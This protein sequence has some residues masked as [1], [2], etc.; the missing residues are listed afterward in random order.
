MNIRLIEAGDAENFL[1]LSKK[2]DESGFMLFDP[3]ERQTSVEQQRKSIEGML[4]QPN[5]IFFVAEIEN[6]LAGYIGVLGSGL[7][8]NQHSATIV[9]GVQETYQGKGV[10]TKLFNKAFEWAKEAGILRL[11]LTVLKHNHKAFNLYKKMGFVLE[12]ERVHSLKIEGEFVNE[13]YLYKLL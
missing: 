3:G 1:E 6:E 5:T 8:R 4:S 11:G 13:Y 7:N 9:L 12:G 2:I 10:A